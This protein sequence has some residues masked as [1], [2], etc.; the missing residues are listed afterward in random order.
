MSTA[1]L[2]EHQN[3]SNCNDFTRRFCA[4]PDEA[5]VLHTV[6]LHIEHNGKSWSD[7][8]PLFSPGIK[9]RTKRNDLRLFFRVL[10]LY[11]SVDMK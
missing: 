9:Y 8:C 10:G 4:K 2:E 3:Q 1:V 6:V 7:V 5:A 11:Q